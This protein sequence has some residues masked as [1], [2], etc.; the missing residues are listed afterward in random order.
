MF[1]SFARHFFR[2]IQHADRPFAHDPQPDS[3]RDG[4]PTGSYPER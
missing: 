1:A 2:A 4:H 3:S